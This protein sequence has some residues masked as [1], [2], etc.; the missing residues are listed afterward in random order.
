MD[1][2]DVVERIF[3]FLTHRERTLMRTTSK[4]F[5]EVSDSLWRRLHSNKKPVLQIW[6][7]NHLL[8]TKSNGISV[9]D[10]SLIDD[11]RPKIFDRK[12][13]LFFYV[14]IIKKTAHFFVESHHGCI[15]A[16]SMDRNKK[17]LLSDI[18]YLDKI[19]TILIH[20]WLMKRDSFDNKASK[21]FKVEIGD[22]QNIRFQTID[23]R[24][25]F[26]LLMSEH[27]KGEQNKCHECSKKPYY[28]IENNQKTNYPLEI[29]IGYDFLILLIKPFQ[30]WKI[31]DYY[32]LRIDDVL[33][34]TKEMYHFNILRITKNV[35][36][37]KVQCFSSTMWFRFFVNETTKE[38][39]LLR[40]PQLDD[41]GCV[42]R[43]IV[44]K[45]EI[46]IKHENKLNIHKI[47]NHRL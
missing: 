32:S 43:C 15:V 40:L 30:V 7:E 12:K 35:T 21:D 38:I 27:A 23:S 13:G 16:F 25:S 28:Q 39:H 5:C 36:L 17:R 33:L 45:T 9:K 46:S 2:H 42:V 10:P 47:N 22:L 24:S 29:K 1:L 14:G 26:R 19:D 31:P 41:V 8:L 20:T 11:C 44:E 3:Y 6:Y 37:L 34:D 4:L 18:H